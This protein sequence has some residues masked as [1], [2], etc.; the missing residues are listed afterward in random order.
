MA[1]TPELIPNVKWT[2]YYAFGGQR[3]A[4]RDNIGA[5][6]GT[7]SWLHGDHLG[8]AS[9]ATNSS[10]AKTSELRY[11]P[12]G[13]VRTIW[14]SMPTDRKF[15]GYAREDGIGA[16]IMRTHALTVTLSRAGSSIV[17]RLGDEVTRA[18][19]NPVSLRNRIFVLYQ[20]VQVARYALLTAP[21]CVPHR[22]G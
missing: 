21:A 7:V 4:V 11:T 10:G 17:P 14:G 16:S 2:Q 9:V 8:S 12:F 6:A 19:K 15:T 3:V 5:A 1:T 20:I 18:L 22:R 13:S